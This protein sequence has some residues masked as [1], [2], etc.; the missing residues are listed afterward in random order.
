MNTEERALY[1]LK[2]AAYEP[3]HHLDLTA[4]NKSVNWLLRS[5]L[6]VEHG[7][8]PEEACGCGH[9]VLT[10]AGLDRAAEYGITHTWADEALASESVSA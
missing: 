8:N 2:K 3:E 10:Q 4:S 1:E 6:A 5:G 9:Y 7:R